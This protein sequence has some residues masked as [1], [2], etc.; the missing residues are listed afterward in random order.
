M[1]V[2]FRDIR[3][4]CRVLVKNPAF[5]T[6]AV[7]TLAVAG[8]SAGLALSLVLTPFLRSMLFGLTEMDAPTIASVSLLLCFV[9][10]SACY[11]PARRA[12]RTE[13][14]IA[15]RYE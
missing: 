2:M 13:P 5:T 14:V 3:Y 9:T 1:E 7:L 15:L 6:I 10:L 4:A 12:A 8:L 11:L